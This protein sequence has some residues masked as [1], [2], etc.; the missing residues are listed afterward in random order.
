MMLLIITVLS[1]LPFLPPTRDKLNEH[2]SDVVS[3]SYI[4]CISVPRFRMCRAISLL[5]HTV[6]FS[7]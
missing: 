3:Y 5:C 6:I 2:K 7:I 1:T 4:S